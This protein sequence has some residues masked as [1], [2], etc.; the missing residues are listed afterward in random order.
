MQPSKLAQLT[1][2]PE[3]QNLCIGENPSNVNEIEPGRRRRSI[4]QAF[5]DSQPMF[6]RPLLGTFYPRASSNEL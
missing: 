1:L 5:Q 4:T 6:P 3:N 2:P